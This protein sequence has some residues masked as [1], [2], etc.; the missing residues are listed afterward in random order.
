[1][2]RA[3][4]E[5]IKAVLLDL[6]MP[7]MGGEEAFRLMKEIRPEIPVIISTGYAENEVREQF[8]GETMLNLISK[9]YSASTLRARI[10]EV[11][12]PPQ[13]R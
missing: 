4:A 8:T 13:K 2:F 11:W 9:P 12:R 10:A 3:N 5:K 1:M 6:T 7:V